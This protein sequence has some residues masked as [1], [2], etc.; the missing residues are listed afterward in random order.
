MLLSLR[1]R[2]Q[3][4]LL[5]TS[6]LLGVISILVLGACSEP[7]AE[8]AAV[9]EA[10]PD[11]GVVR[12]DATAIRV[13][14]IA[15]A[16][17]ERETVQSE[18]RV[19]GRITLNE[20]ATSRVGSFTEG[21][22]VDCCEPVGALVK[23]GQ[24]VARIHSHEVHDAE[25][26]HRRAHEELQQAKADLAYATQVHSR[27]SR[28]Y[29]LKAG[30]LQQVQEAEA[31]LRRAETSVEIAE[32]E[33]RRAESHLR[34]LGF[35]P[36][37]LEHPEKQQSPESHESG[38]DTHLLEVRSPV[39][40]TVME[41]LASPG[42][43]VTPSDTLYVISNLNQLWI[44]AQVPEQQL[45]AIREGMTADVLVAA[46]PGRTFSARVIRV[47]DTLDA[48][49][50]TVQARCEIAN[51]RRELKTEMYVTMVF[52][53][54]SGQQAIVA[55]ASAVQQIDDGHVV[56]VPITEGE[57]LARPVEVG[58]QYGD[59]IEIL[60]GLSEGEKVVVGGSFSLKSELLKGRMIEE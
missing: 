25:S 4:T 7:A 58:R 49:T 23:K 41:R 32:A 35:D 15:L 54:G 1:S 19:S 55:P 13:A 10:P 6:L 40:G 39:S 47:E 5:T 26:S 56:F 21:V 50:R 45:S 30:S 34:Y 9:E 11:P 48:E 18:V 43:V 42:A 36:P 3:R 29:E 37:D 57:F 33:L 14:G 44:T 51:P 16:S 52:R 22:I 17:V 46:Y 2:T 12:L 24:V 28:L 27:A 59:K 53:T 8:S 60:K 31:A 38:H 20:N